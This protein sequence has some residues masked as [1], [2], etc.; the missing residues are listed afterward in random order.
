MTTS[1]DFFLIST[2]IAPSIEPTECFV[3]QAIPTEAEEGSYVLVVK[4]SP[5]IVPH[6][7]WAPFY[8]RL[9]E[10]VLTAAKSGYTLNP[11]NKWPV[12]VH[13]CQPLG[14]EARRRGKV[15]KM[16]LRAIYLGAIHPTFE[17]ADKIVGIA[18]AISPDLSIIG[19]SG[20]RFAWRRQGQSGPNAWTTALGPESEPDRIRL[21]VNAHVRAFLLP[22]SK[23][24]L[25]Y[26]SGGRIRV[27]GFDPDRLADFSFTDLPKEF[28][29]PGKL[30]PYYAHGT[31]EFEFSLDPNVPEGILHL[32]FP[33]D[34]EGITEIFIV[35]PYLPR[36][37]TGH[38]Y[39]EEADPACVI[40]ALRPTRHQLAVLPQKWFTEKEFDVD[41][42]WIAAIVRYSP[43]GR[44][45]GGGIRIRPFELTE[46]GCHLERW[47]DEE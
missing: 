7:Q 37:A 41:Y 10:A 6:P 8:I 32:D 5:P 44:L 25:W 11:V 39:R 12:P 33:T 28:R 27:G 29:R 34:L 42:Q 19:G 31:P 23:V 20:K 13:V 9:E 45:I 36:V 22:P 16:S 14:E 15:S 1:P 2:D 3:E 26:P 35:A 30:M 43:T 47:L 24:G 21:A 40:L 18:K 4:L 38:R 46:D 17:D